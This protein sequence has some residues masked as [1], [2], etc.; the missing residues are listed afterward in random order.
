MQHLPLRIQPH[1]LV[2]GPFRKVQSETP[3]QG[4]ALIGL[5]FLPAPRL[6]GTGAGE[7]VVEESDGIVPF[8]GHAFEGEPAVVRGSLGIDEEG[9]EEGVD[10]GEE[11]GQV[12]EAGGVDL[13]RFVNTYVGEPAVW[14]IAYEVWIC[15]IIDSAVGRCESDFE[16]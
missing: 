9:G 10:A 5:G 14:E 16:R 4:L 13:V 8:Q 12:G 11:E 3:R 6:R 7:E 2:R 1:E 15:L